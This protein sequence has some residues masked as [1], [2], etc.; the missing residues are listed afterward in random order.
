MLYSP[1][2]L[3]MVSE[4]RRNRFELES[5]VV[6]AVRKIV[7]HV[8]PTCQSYLGIHLTYSSVCS[9]LSYLVSYVERI[10]I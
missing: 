9:K 1:G 10:T 3:V 8:H 4:T 6:P 5:R 7:V 2:R